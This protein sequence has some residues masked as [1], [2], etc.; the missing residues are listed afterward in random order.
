MF[1]IDIKGEKPQLGGIPKNQKVIFLAKTAGG[2]F[3]VITAPD[4]FNPDPEKPIDGLASRNLIG[5]LG[6]R[7]EFKDSPITNGFWINDRGFAH[8][9]DFAFS[10]HSQNGS[11][12]YFLGGNELSEV[13]IPL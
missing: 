5:H 6:R 4:D 13:I 7:M 2:D 8:G 9:E 1:I 12:K 11:R 3:C 10:Y